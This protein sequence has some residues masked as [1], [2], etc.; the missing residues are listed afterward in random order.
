MPGE[1]GARYLRLVETLTH[2]RMHAETIK[3]VVRGIPLVVQNLLN[4]PCQPY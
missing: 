2:K 4:G 1:G 3:A